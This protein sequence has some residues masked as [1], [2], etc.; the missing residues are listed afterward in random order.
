LQKE[1]TMTVSKRTETIIDRLPPNHQLTPSM[2]SVMA[3]ALTAGEQYAG[4]KI[5]IASDKRMTE[6][7]KRQALKDEF[8]G[9]FGK[10]LVRAKQHVAKSRAEIK[11][12]R[13]A[14]VV[15]SVEPA[16]L[17]AALERQ[18]IRA[19]I[20]SLDPGVRQSTVLSSRDRRIFEAMLTAPPE[21]SGIAGSSAAAEIEARYLELTYPDELASIEAMDSV[22]S[23]A[24][25][26]MDVA[27]NDLAGVVDFLHPHEFDVLLKGIDVGRPWLID[28]RRQVCETGIDGKPV[29]RKATEADLA[30]GVEYKNFD[31]YRAAQ[32]IAA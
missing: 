20:R 5:A 11:A 2:R 32:G 10:T 8:T 9:R 14:L 7:G 1:N 13:D 26:A 12:R 15:K 17:A 18:E 29:Y 19:W 27:R 30:D 16:N 6:L 24:E 31:E 4:Y 3:D 25:A 28:G 23:E 21:L 22:V